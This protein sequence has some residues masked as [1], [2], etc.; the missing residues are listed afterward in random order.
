MKILIVEDEPKT[1]AYLTK[2]LIENGY[3]VDSASN[4]EMGLHLAKTIHFDL[5]ILDVM[6][7]DLD[8]WSVMKQMRESG[9]EKP[10]LFLTAR[11][12]VED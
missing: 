1:V 12:A 3:R 7:P 10:V 11:D 8:G 9:I 6:L 5:L 2:G 4:G